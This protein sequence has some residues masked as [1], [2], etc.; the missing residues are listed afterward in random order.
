MFL[1]KFFFLQDPFNSSYHIKREKT[2]FLGSFSLQK[3]NFE[4]DLKAEEVRS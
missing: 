4:R 2:S 1:T 3:L